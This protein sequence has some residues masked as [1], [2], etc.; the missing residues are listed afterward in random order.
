MRI[1][2]VGDVVGK[3]G[4]T[5]LH[6]ELPR[7]KSEHR[8]DFCIVNAE[9]SAGGIGIT[10][11]I[12]DTMLR[13]GAD[14]L[15]L[16]NHAWGK[17]EIFPYLDEEAR[18][19]RPANYPPGAPGQGFGVYQHPKGAVGVVSLQ[20]RTFMEPVDDPFRAIDAILETLA[21]RC[22]IVFVDFH[23]EA[24]SEKQAFGWYV[25]GRVSAVV[26]THTH[27]QTA[28]ERIL[29]EGTA[30]L[31][32]V[33]MTGPMISVIGMRCDIVVPKFTSLIPARFEVA[34][35]EAQL[36]GVVIEINETTGHAVTIYRVQT[37]AHTREVPGVRD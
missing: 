32:D 35:G 27:I 29:P 20:G 33:G 23:A 12:A 26:G 34:D 10:P 8:I 30:Y 24:T 3:P 21:T 6:E 9:N 17:R 36:C 7:L 5:V 37:P 28:D 2:M 31:T 13:Q 19:L 25:D 14:V 4:R 1:L 11:D 18:L 15:T 16:G 22:K